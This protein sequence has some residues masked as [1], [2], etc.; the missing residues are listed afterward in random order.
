M[1]SIQH[2]LLFLG[3]ILFIPL[4]LSG[5]ISYTS[6]FYPAAGNPGNFNTTQDFENLGWNTILFSGLSTNQWSGDESIP[7]GFS[8]YGQPV[9]I[10]KVSANGVLNFSQ[11]GNNPPGANTSIPDP[12]FPDLSIACFW[13]EFTTNPPTG[14]NDF[15]YTRVF[16]FPPFRQLWI[17]WSSFEWGVADFAYV[18]IVLEETTNKIYLVD[19]Y[20][21]TNS[22]LTSSTAGLQENNSNGVMAGNNIP[23][24][25]LGPANSDNQYYEFAPYN[26]QPLDVEP[27]SVIYP[28]EIGC[29]LNQEAISFS[30][31][32]IGQGQAMGVEASFSVNG[33]PFSSKEPI[34]GT[35]QPGDTIN[36]TFNTLA[37]LGGIG[38][39]TLAIALNLNGDG[40]QTNDTLYFSLK[41]LLHI[42]SFPYHETFESGNGGWESSGQNSSWELALPANDTIN[43]AYSGAHAW[44]TNASGNYHNN[45]HSQVESPCFDLTNLASDSWVIFQVW[46]ESEYSWDGAVLQAST[47]LGKTWENVGSLGTGTNWFNDTTINGIPG[48]QLSGWTGT[49]GTANGSDGWVQARHPLHNNLMGMDE[50]RFRIAFGSD[51]VYTEDGFAFDDFVIAQAPQVN[52]GQ[53]GFYCDGDVLDAGNPG[54]SYQ[55]STGATTQTI[56]LTNTTG[57]NIIDSLVIVTVTDSFGLVT[58]DSLMFS[59]NPPIVF[60]LGQAQNIDCFGESTGAIST[61]I[62]NGMTPFTFSWNHGATSQ[63]ITGLPAGSYQVVATDL[64]GCVDSLGPIILTESPEITLIATFQDI[65]C[66]GDDNGFIDVTAL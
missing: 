2:F 34:P 39:H 49:S 22:V 50:V 9:S 55:W 11:T 27:V 61:I 24:G 15:V 35:L 26:V 43:Q 32:N 64:N 8:F 37:N 4:H 46:W 30:L 66:F 33:G 5:Q 18:A 57:T 29:G 58:T 60:N 48:G 65:T 20:S 40:D 42:S 25:A 12:A 3:T 56:T 31:T 13:E 36:Y 21:S 52:L 28:G 6:A 10:F 19:M 1:K 63:N 38:T 51:A 16:G 62:F 53:N 41:N 14:S 23:L 47:D 17:K 44:I 54:Q 45:E 7:F 59:M